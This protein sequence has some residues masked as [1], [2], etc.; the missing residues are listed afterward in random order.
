MYH[1]WLTRILVFLF[2]LPVICIGQTK[3]LLQRTIIDTLDFTEKSF[4]IPPFQ[5][6]L[7]D[8]KLTNDW[9][10]D[11]TF[12]IDLGKEELGILYWNQDNQMR[13]IAQAGMRVPIPNRSVKNNSE[14]MVIYLKAY[15]TKNLVLEIE[16][17]LPTPK[18][19]KPQ[20]LSHTE[21]QITQ[22]K[23]NS[24]FYRKYWIPGYISILI[25]VLILTLVQYFVLPERLFVYYFFY[26]FFTF[27]RS[28]AATEVIVLEDWAPLLN[29]LGYSSLQSQVFTYLSF[30]FYVLFLRD[31]TSFP[32]KKPRLDYFFKIQLAYL[33]VF[34]V[35][36]L[37][38]PTEKYSN[39]QLNSI[40]RALEM[41]GLV[42]GIINLLLLFK[43]YDSFNKFIIIG[44][45]LLY[46]IGIVG[47]EII[48]QSLNANGEPETY[49][50]ALSIVWASAYLVEIAFFTISLVNR[51][52]VLLKSI[53]HEQKQNE[54]LTAQLVSQKTTM[55]KDLKIGYESFSL[56][57]N[58]GVLVFQ[59]SDIIR[60]E[61]SGNYTIF[62]TH[63]RQQTLAS[64][65]L[66]EFEPRLNPSKFIRVHK[67]HL[68]NL[69]YVV[70][71]T[72]GDGG[73]LTL[74]DGSE[75]PV[76]RSRKDE[77]LKRL[78]TVK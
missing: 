25:A 56:A 26:I 64:Y 67:S 51:Q 66:G 40:F 9:E 43:V 11:T 59:Q 68:V 30:V 52:R 7:L 31:F 36:D 12:Y 63:K 14:A 58:K 19:V 24:T 35:F 69:D 71:Y 60:L 78:P 22:A 41:V 3:G 55:A 48:K 5:T 20:L 73:T 76:S 33:A 4:T 54:L 57:T 15:E 65:T 72:K 62:S 50:S 38:F 46:L 32:S 75:I 21:Y 13:K 45:A 42:L 28:T 39:F 74:Q 77:V 53:L 27:I 23:Q 47:Q 18:L 17:F 34:I 1:C 70:K 8:C 61:A 16:N 37:F 44:A 2:I 10:K 49:R 6:L 29:R